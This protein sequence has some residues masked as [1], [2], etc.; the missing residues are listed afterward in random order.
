MITVPSARYDAQGKGGI[1]NISTRTSRTGRAFSNCP[2]A[3]LMGDRPGE[4]IKD[5][6]V[7]SAYK[8]T[9]CGM[10]EGSIFYMGKDKTRFVRGIELQPQKCK[11][12]ADWRRKVLDVASGCL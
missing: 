1:V 12:A 8:M 4:K 6:D 3:N 7:Y 10:G 2:H 5:L 11:W 9:D